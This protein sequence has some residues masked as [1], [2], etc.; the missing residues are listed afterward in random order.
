MK[1]SRVC[2]WCDLTLSEGEPGSPVSH[3]ICGSCAA[4]EKAKNLCR[5]TMLI[6]PSQVFSEEMTRDSA[7]SLL[8]A[9]RHNENFL[10][11]T[12]A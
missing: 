11:Y 10:S 8:Q 12:V 4:K 9:I 5:L 2:A 1:L 3:G 7:A 6:S